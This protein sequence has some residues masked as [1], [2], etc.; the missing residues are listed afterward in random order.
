MTR[1]IWVL[2]AAAATVLVSVLVAVD[3]LPLGISG[4]WTWGRVRTAAYWPETW[5]YSTAYVVFVVVAA[6]WVGERPWLRRALL[7]ALVVASFTVGLALQ[8]PGYGPAK[9]AFVLFNPSSSGYYTAAKTHVTT[10]REFIGDYNRIQDEFLRD[11][12]PYHLATHPPGL[13]LMHYAVLRWCERHPAWSRACLDAA[14]AGVRDGFAALAGP[15]QPIPVADQASRWL[16]G[17][18]SQLACAA[19]VIPIY[20]LARRVAGPQAAW[21]AAGLWP[22][23]PAT[24]I[25]MA[26]SDV[27]YPLF[28]TTTVLFALAG[29]RAA[30]RVA[31]G[32]AAGLVLWLGMYFTVGLVPVIPLVAVAVMMTEGIRTRSSLVACIRLGAAMTAAF[33]VAT[34]AYVVVTGHDLTATWLNCFHAHAK[35]YERHPRSYW[36]WLGFDLAEFVVALGLPLAV[37]AVAGIAQLACHRA[38]SA[39]SSEGLENVQCSDEAGPPRC[40]GLVWAWCLTLL[41]L[42]LSGENLGEV[43]R[44]W[45]FLMPFAVPAAAATIERLGHWAWPAFLLLALQAGQTIVF[46]ANIQGFIDPNSVILP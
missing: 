44:L 29:N 18:F 2:I 25:F 22:L 19:T 39:S 8:L 32:L 1:M 36:P 27:L 12:G 15:S 28:A 10:P 33:A 7:L 20:L 3:R 46:A 23:V 14:P 38:N 31:G 34:A 43:A 21:W 37:A 30:S 5:G 41:A 9:W 40:R 4:E 24:T 35:F 42:D 45:I 16:V 17:L 6:R 26:K 11:N 13:V